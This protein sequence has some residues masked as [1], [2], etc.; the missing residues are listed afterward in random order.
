MPICAGNRK[1]VQIKVNSESKDDA[2]HLHLVDDTSVEPTD[3]FGKMPASKTKD[4]KTL[5]KARFNENAASYQIDFM[6]PLQ[7]HRGISI[8]ES[9]NVEPGSLI[10]YTR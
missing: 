4:H 8:I 2:L 1:I 3:K 5:V 9:V 6:E 7:V 10:A